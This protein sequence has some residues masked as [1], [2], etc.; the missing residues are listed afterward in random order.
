MEA[1]TN[2]LNTMNQTESTAVKLNKDYRKT[3]NE[4]EN[5]DKKLKEHLKL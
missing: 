1:S 5:K 3:I 2:F 4:Q